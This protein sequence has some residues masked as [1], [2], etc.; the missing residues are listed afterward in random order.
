MLVAVLR[1]EVD[2]RGADLIDAG[3]VVGSVVRGR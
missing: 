2:E 3:H 1:K